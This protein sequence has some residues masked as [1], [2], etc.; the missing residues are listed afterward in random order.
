MS[1]RI[2]G[3]KGKEDRKRRKEREGEKKKGEGTFHINRLEDSDQRPF[4]GGVHRP[5]MRRW[6]GREGGKGGKRKRCAKRRWL[7]NLKER[8]LILEELFELNYYFI[9]YLF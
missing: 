1:N 5:M 8:N 6:G 3:K 9:N 4:L 2:K 7:C